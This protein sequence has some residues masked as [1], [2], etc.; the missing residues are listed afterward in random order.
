M[1]YLRFKNKIKNQKL[2]VHLEKVKKGILQ[3]NSKKNVNLKK[4]INFK[5]SKM[6]IFGLFDDRFRHRLLYCIG[7][8][9]LGDELSLS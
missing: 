8:Q 5:K 3:S 1:T 6:Y 9:A 4:I 7:P 2:Y